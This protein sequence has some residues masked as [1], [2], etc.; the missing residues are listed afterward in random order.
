MGK[1]LPLR[2]NVPRNAALDGKASVAHRGLDSR[3]LNERCSARSHE[4]GD[5]YIV[6]LKGGDV[7]GRPRM[8]VPRGC[9]VDSGGSR[10]DHDGY[11][12]FDDAMVGS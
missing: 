5:P 6:L 1:S 2:L 10:N 3:P 4:A 7:G 11:S 12:I 9:E 8:T